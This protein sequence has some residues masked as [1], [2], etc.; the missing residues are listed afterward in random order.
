MRIFKILIIVLFACLIPVSS[1]TNSQDWVRTGDALYSQYRFQDAITAYDNALRLDPNNADA[2]SKRQFVQ[3]F[4][5]QYNNIITSIGSNYVDLYINL[6]NKGWN[7]L[8]FL[9]DHSSLPTL[10]DSAWL[11]AM[12]L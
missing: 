6:I 8:S 4:A 5:G 3:Q 1:Q 2:Q 7:L 12:N 10:A 9:R 11:M